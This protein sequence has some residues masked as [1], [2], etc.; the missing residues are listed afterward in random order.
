MSFFLMKHHELQA[1]TNHPTTSLTHQF[2][3]PSSMVSESEGAAAIL[4]SY[5]NTLS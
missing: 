2:S 4:V 1:A 3:A 5:K